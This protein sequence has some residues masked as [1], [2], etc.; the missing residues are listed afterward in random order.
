MAQIVMDACSA[1]LLAKATVLE[2][3]ANA[4]TI[5][6]TKEVYKEVMA[7]KPKMFPD[8]LLIERLVREQKIKLNAVDS[9]LIRKLEQD[10]NM[11]SGE[12]S[13]VA[14]G[15]RVNDK[16][17][18]TDNRQGRTAA[19]INNLK[20]IGSIEI[21]VALYKSKK[22]SK[23]KAMTALKT[24]QEEGWFEPLLIEMAQEDLK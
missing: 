24:L 10:F 18:A 14:E 9:T 13:V 19:K 2:T 23:D 8:A 17:I 21:I 16:I 3:V 1:I 5:T 20:V 22:I 4:H 7:G 15:I 11:G 6:L 12:A